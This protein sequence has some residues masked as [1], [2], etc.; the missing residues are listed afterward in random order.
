MIHLCS[1]LVALAK[2]YYYTKPKVSVKVVEDKEEEEKKQ[3]ASSLLIETINASITSKER[4]LLRELCERLSDFINPNDSTLSY[5]EA[6]LITNRSL[7]DV[8][9]QKDE[10]QAVDCLNDKKQR[11]KVFNIHVRIKSIFVC[12]SLR[13]F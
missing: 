1:I 2:A 10:K 12:Y 13:L 9:Y 6:W 7:I 8:W 11:E 3:P 4:Q 5:E